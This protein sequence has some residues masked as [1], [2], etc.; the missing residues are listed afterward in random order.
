MD[1]VPGQSASRELTATPEM[2]RAYAEIT[3]VQSE[4]LAASIG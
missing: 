4:A 1:C 3:E 2:V